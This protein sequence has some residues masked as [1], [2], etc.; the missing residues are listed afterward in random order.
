MCY[1]NSLLTLTLTLHVKAE[2]TPAKLQPSSQ[3]SA[4][5]SQSTQWEAD[6]L[7]RKREELDKRAAE[8]D[9]REQDMQR[10]V[11]FQ[12]GNISLFLLV[13]LNTS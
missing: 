11:Q 13:L 3:T 10:T 1:I 9:R 12:G 8:L 5:G 6:E 7:Q 4:A 2:T